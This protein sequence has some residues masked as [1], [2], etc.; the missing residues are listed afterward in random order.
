MAEE[1]TITEEEVANNATIEEIEG[2]VM[3]TT[4]NEDI[5]VEQPEDN[6][7][8]GKFKTNEDL[9]A[10]YQE[11]EKNYHSKGEPVKS[12]NPLEIPEAPETPEAPEVL[13]L[14]SYEQEYADNGTLSEESYEAL[15]AQGYDKAI[16]DGYIQGQ[17]ALAAQWVNEVQSLAGGSEEY[18]KM[19]EWA[20]AN[21][22]EGFVKSFNESIGSKD[23][24]KAQMAVEA[25]KSRYQSSNGS[26]PTL[27]E[28]VPATTDGGEV[29]E[30]WAQY[31]EDAN[32]DKYMKDPAFRDKV[33]K[34]LSRS[35]I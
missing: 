1:H 28:G 10:A 24:N 2:G 20:V 4:G 29:Y 23:S 25:L 32:S 17:Q 12:D 15:K 7:I 26:E 14:T 22:D 31:V 33:M 11:L 27:I 19:V 9:L 5:P 13:D 6:L 16:V 3:I 35:Q 8:G 30:S 18:Q 34:K 21:T